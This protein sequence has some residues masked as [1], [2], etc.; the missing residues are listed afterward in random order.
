MEFDNENN[1][2]DNESE[3]GRVIKV[4]TLVVVAGTELVSIF[5]QHALSSGLLEQQLLACISE[6]RECGEDCSGNEHFI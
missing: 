1:E 5:H 6:C 2:A 4:L 3:H